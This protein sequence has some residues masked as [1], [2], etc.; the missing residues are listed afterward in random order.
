VGRQVKRKGHQ[1]F[2]EEV[3]E[4]INSDVIYLIVG[5]GPEHE[6]I[7]QAKK[8]S[9]LGNKIILAGKFPLKC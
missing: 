9:K 2:I 3:M 4:K 5:D 1:W 7:R 6:S 8:S